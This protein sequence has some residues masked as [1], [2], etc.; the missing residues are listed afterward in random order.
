[1]GGRWFWSVMSH[2]TAMSYVGEEG[3]MLR[4]S[5]TPPALSG[6]LMVKEISEWCTQGTG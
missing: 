4:D 1:M 5:V 2:A 3:D 6:R